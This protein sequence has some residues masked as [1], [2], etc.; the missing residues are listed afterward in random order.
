MSVMD[1]CDLV[2]MMADKFVVS[3]AAAVS[4]AAGPV[5]GPVEASEE[6]TEFDVVLG[7]AGSNKIA[8]IKAGRGATGLGLKEATDAVEGT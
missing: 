6:K 3:D 1:V 7:D 5:A 8:A 4:V 2:K